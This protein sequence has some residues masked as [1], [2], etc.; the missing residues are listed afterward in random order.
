[1]VVG[2][3][4]RA[5]LAGLIVLVLLVSLT[6]YLSSWKTPV[7]RQ[8]TIIQEQ[9]TEVSGQILIYVNNRLAY[10]GQ[11]HSFLKPVPTM[12]AVGIFPTSSFE[13]A[14]GVSFYSEK[15]NTWDTRKDAG[16]YNP[17]IRY[18]GAASGCAASSTTSSDPVGV[19]GMYASVSLLLL[20][21][22]TKG[23]KWTEVAVSTTPS[24]TINATGI[25]LSISGS[26][27]PSL[28]AAANVSMIRLVRP[29][30]NAQGYV[31]PNIIYAVRI[32]E[33]TLSS[34]VTVNPGDSLTVVYQFYFKS[35]Q[36]FT[37]NWANVTFAWLYN[38][39]GAKT[40]V[41]ATDGSTGYVDPYA[42]SYT[43]PAN[44]APVNTYIVV[45]N[46]QASFNRTA[47]KVVSEVARAEPSVQVYTGGV[48]L[49][50]AF[51]FSQDT[52][53]TEL[54]VYSKLRDGKEVMLLYYVLPK[55]VTAKAGVP[56]TVTFYINLP[57]QDRV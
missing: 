29:M 27:T 39:P 42:S 35:D 31:Y 52:T 18:G 46:G 22:D 54:A 48:S 4:L 13:S 47:Y 36:L 50:Y 56:F 30:G 51:T 28:T 26:V 7:D 20:I 23:N 43:S 19:W 15:P 9:A 24:I 49:S 17:S 55:P 14:G 53:I 11:V 57:W 2:K 6:A 32:A 44:N 12:L 1:M 5:V 10:R 16:T 37:K 41:T 38:V 45:G 34:P 40:A 33:D 25:L 3:K 21:Y 8:A